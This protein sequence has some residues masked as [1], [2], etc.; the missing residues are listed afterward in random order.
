MKIDF[1]W[2]SIGIIIV[3][4]VLLSLI[5]FIPPIPKEFAY[6]VNIENISV[7]SN[8]GHPSDLL[9]SFSNADTFVVSPALD[10]KNVYANS[11]TDSL[12]VFLGVLEGSQKKTISLIRKFNEDNELISCR[13][14]YGDLKTDEEVSVQECNRILNQ[15][16]AVKILISIPN[17]KLNKTTVIIEDKM[18]LI[19]PKGTFD[20]SKASLLLLKAMFSNAEEILN[21]I[22]ELTKKIGV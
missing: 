15:E 18:I 6:E 9:K 17:N 11:A 12:L 22:N 20:G 16:N 14:N 21:K 19:N 1:K 5:F 7:Y 3:I 13:T 4:L 8:L 10:A 2:L